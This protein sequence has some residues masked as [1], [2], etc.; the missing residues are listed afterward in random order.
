MS[1]S[2]TPLFTLVHSIYTLVRATDLITGIKERNHNDFEMVFR[3]YY[4]PLCQYAAIFIK[5]DDEARDL[6][7]KLFLQLWENPEKFE[8][9]VSIQGLLYTAVKNRSLN[10]L[11][12]EKVKREHFKS[13]QASSHLHVVEEGN[14]THLEK[15][16]QEAINLLPEQCRKVFELSRL[17]GLRY[18]EIADTMNISVKTVEAHMGKALRHMREQLSDYLTL[19]L[20]LFP[21]LIQ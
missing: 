12:H 11:R 14:T 6:V 3:E 4:S 15:E 17:D 9:N 13:E 19:L 16:I 2:Q 8:A 20:L 7:Q 1:H 5:N 18:R 21:T 10:W